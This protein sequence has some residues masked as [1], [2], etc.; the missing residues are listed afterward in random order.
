MAISLSASD[1]LAAAKTRTSFATPDVADRSF[2]ADRA[3][4]GSPG[5]QTYEA[6]VTHGK[7]GTQREVIFNKATFY[8]PSASA[9]RKN[10]ARHALFETMGAI[11]RLAHPITPF[12]SED[13]WSRLPNTTGFVAQAPYP[14]PEDYEHDAAVLDE[15]A[16][17][18]EAITEV[19]DGAALV[20]PCAA[21]TDSIGAVDADLGLLDE[22]G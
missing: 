8:D 11:V 14:R 10:A 19:Q 15:L 4:L 6:H 7:H 12:L 9:A 17:L 5:T 16:V 3:L 22:E 2:T 1:R 13:I 18:Q 21:A 20:P